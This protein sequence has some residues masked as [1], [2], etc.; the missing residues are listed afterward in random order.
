[1]RLGT[2]SEVQVGLTW[3]R[4]RLGAG[5]PRGWEAAC[6]RVFV[7]ALALLGCGV[8]WADE[9]IVDG[10]AP[11][12]PTVWALA[13][14]AAAEPMDQSRQRWWIEQ[15]W[16]SC[17]C[18]G[19]ECSRAVIDLFALPQ[20]LTN[21]ILSPCDDCGRD[22]VVGLA[23]LAVGFAVLAQQA[24]KGYRR[25]WHLSFALFLIL[26]LG[27]TVFSFFPLAAGSTETANLGLPEFAYI[28]FASAF[29]AGVLAFWTR[30]MLDL[31]AVIAVASL[32]AILAMDLPSSIGRTLLIVGTGVVGGAWLY[33]WR[34]CR[35]KPAAPA[36][37]QAPP[38][39][40]G[41]VNPGHG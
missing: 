10:Q 19:Q 11:N 24:A 23:V 4:P 16:R 27:T 37:G 3:P 33:W 18:P 1:M 28:L 38:A 31:L 5:Q 9:A 26:F 17:A 25:H 14:E 6:R 35:K 40:G 39:A 2:M 36:D 7:V 21:K 13:L 30:Y 20:C 12:D 29:L 32:A 34:E 8:V 22:K 41:G 15:A